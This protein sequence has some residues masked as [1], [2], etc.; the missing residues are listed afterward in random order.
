MAAF[1][2][3]KGVEVRQIL[4]KPIQG[5][6]TEFRIDG[7]SGERQIGVEWYDDKNQ[8]HERFFQETEIELTKPIKDEADSEGK[9]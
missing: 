4:P 8:H 7:T 6:V 9:A 5:R 3:P 1:K 2:F